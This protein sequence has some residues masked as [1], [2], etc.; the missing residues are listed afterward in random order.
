MKE[1]KN[2]KILNILLLGLL[3]FL[4][5]YGFDYELNYFYNEES[6]AFDYFLALSSCLLLLIY[7]L[8]LGYLLVR[9]ADD[10]GVDKRFTGLSLIAGMFIPGFLA[11]LANDRSGEFIRGIFSKSFSDSWTLAFTAP[12][13]EEFIKLILVLCLLYLFKKK[14]LED[15]FIGGFAV[16]LG[17]Q[18]MEDV[19]YIGSDGLA[20]MNRL[21]PLAISRVSGS[22]SSHWTY[23]ALFCLGFYFIIK[24]RKISTGLFLMLFVFINHFLWDSPFGAFQAFTSFLAASML[25]CM[26]FMVNKYIKKIF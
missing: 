21:F 7:I 2:N 26:I 9:M 10:L 20:D 11:A 12:F 1:R 3:I 17:F 6:G 13:N 24:K 16:G 8:P 19:S 15:F 18:I 23:T 25:V 4:F 22:L 5:V 14:D